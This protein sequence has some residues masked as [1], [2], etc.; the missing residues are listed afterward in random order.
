MDQ[1]ETVDDGRYDFRYRFGHAEFDEAG[2]H[3]RV[4]GAAVDVERRALE[5]L[6][7]LLRHAGE[8]VTKDEL[9]QEVWAGRVTVDKV[10]PN[11]INKLRKALGPDTAPLLVTQPRIGY[12]ITGVRERIVVR[13]HAPSLLTLQAGDPVPMRPSF[14]LARNLGGARGNEVWLGV[15][16]KTD[17]QRVFKYA[18]DG[19]QLH[20]LKR[21]AVLSRLLQ[22]ELGTDPA[23]GIT[24]L[25]DWHFG[26]APFF[27][28]YAFGGMP[29][30]DW[31]AS[32]LAGMS[33]SGRLALFA[34]IAR[35]ID[36][37]HRIGVLH[38][39]LK[40]ANILVDGDA[41]RGWH[42]R[43]VDFG[44]GSLLDPDRLDA[45]GITRHDTL[46]LDNLHPAGTSGSPWYLSPE[47]VAGGPQTIQSDVYALGLILYQLLVGD[48]G[49]PMAPGWEAEVD[50]PLLRED[51]TAATHSD[52]TC[53][54]RAVSDL[55]ERLQ[56]LDSRHREQDEAHRSARQL[57]ALEGE[58]ARRRARRP[59]LLGLFALLGAGLLVSGWLLHEARTARAEAQ[60]ELRT[61]HALTDFINQDLI[62]QA[63]PIINGRR[64]DAT[65]RDVLLAARDRVGDRFDGH[66]QVAARIH[67]TLS[68]LFAS[69][70]MLDV[71]EQEARRALE[72]HT[73]TYGAEA[74]ATLRAQATLVRQLS[75]LGRH[76]DAE[77]ELARMA[78]A[79][80]TPHGAL[81]LAIARGISGVNRGDIP[82]GIPHL[83]SAVALYPQVEPDSLAAL[84][85]LKTDLAQVYTRVERAREADALMRGLIDDLQRRTTPNPLRLAMARQVLA[86]ARTRQ[87]LHADAESLL[88]DAAPVIVAAMGEHSVN[89]MM[90]AASRSL[91]ARKRLDW[92]QA[93]GHSER[94]LAAARI[95][96]GETHVMTLGAHGS[97]GQTLY[98]AGELP[99]AREQLARAHAGLAGQ[100]PLSTP[101]ARNNALWYLMTLSALADWET[102]ASLLHQLDAHPPEGGDGDSE[103]HLINGAR[104]MLLAARDDHTAAAPLLEAAVNHLVQED[105]D[106]R[107]AV[108][109][110]LRRALDAAQ[111]RAEIAGAQ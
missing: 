60:T 5:V 100:M 8:V 71:A 14:Q 78:G 28:E 17:E 19:R 27:L 22:Q 105:D 77:D 65:V 16:A 33:L 99:R 94:H 81:H 93:I 56:A 84:D 86:D 97:L 1:I 61:A 51:I 104:G 9:L 101:L 68:G 45:L 73:R 3:L 80:T 79:D 47:V 42:P 11:A 25:Y 98:L 57:A 44:S 83:E 69:I 85:A 24:R 30:R 20:A 32:H 49:R 21:E 34:G 76:E 12:Q 90:I 26:G 35:T 59:Y 10:L 66:P 50:D 70:E 62:G 31:A 46:P 2:F 95:R 37:A 103:R 58:L 87:G 15:H 53:R 82:G 92:P 52:P 72:I 109:P 4:D 29:L 75:R 107:D 89:A 43:V 6:A 48:I 111:A 13:S 41:A 55:L 110:Q 54:L 67:G 108:G 39:D 88:E 23:V 36:A 102:T 38:K 74:P 96:L 63:N 106:V 7:Y 64:A 18:R 40:P 91:L